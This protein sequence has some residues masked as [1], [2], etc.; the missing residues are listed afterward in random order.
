MVLV[1]RSLTSVPKID[2]VVWCLFP[3][4]DDSSIPGPEPRPDRDGNV[5]RMETEDGDDPY[6]WR[7]STNIWQPMTFK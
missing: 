7:N 3:D 2:D 6:V 1:H 4:G 5:I